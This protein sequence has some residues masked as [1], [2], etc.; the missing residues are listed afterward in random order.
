MASIGKTIVDVRVV[1]DP[2]P[3]K[4]GVLRADP[5]PL[6]VLGCPLPLC[7]CFSLEIVDEVFKTCAMRQEIEQDLALEKATHV[8]ETIGLYAGF[9]VT[10][11]TVGS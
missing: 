9:D 1:V 4:F 11:R 8:Q 7:W 10:Q 5:L 2:P 3:W 6:E